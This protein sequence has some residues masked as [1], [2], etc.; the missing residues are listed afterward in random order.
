MDQ[1]EI[2]AGLIVPTYRGVPIV[3]TSFLSPRTNKMGAVVATKGTGGGLP[4]VALSY[5][6]APVIARFGE[7]QAS[8]VATVTPDADGVVNL[9][10]STPTGPE[11]AQPT[12]YKV[13]RNYTVAGTNAAVTLLGVVDANFLDNTGAAYA[14]TTIVDNGTTLVAKNG[15][16]VQASP[17][18]A[19]AYFNNGLKPLTANGEQSIF[20]MSR[21]PNYI[22][23]PHVREMQAVNV[24]PTTASPDSLPFAFVADTTLA[25]RAPKYIG[26][27]ANVA[28]ALDKTAGNGITPTNNSYTPTFIVD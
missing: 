20:L 22:V 9:A 7:I 4:N 2:A 21:D 15:S 12:H 1:V 6:V 11:G 10:F 14:T 3:K 25:V 5:Q 18:N 27:L 8:T 23:R 28:S 17:T 26:R 13:Y 16:H 19:Y 24:Y